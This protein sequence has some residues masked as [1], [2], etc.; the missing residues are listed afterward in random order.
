MHQESTLKKTT[1]T[2]SGIFYGYW[3]LFVGFVYQIVMNGCVPYGFSLFILPID[4]E[5]GWSRAVI[6]TG[7]MIA[8]LITG[9]ASPFVGK[10]IYRIGARWVLAGG[11]LLM[12]IGFAALSMT[13]TVWQFYLLYAVVGIGAAATGVVPT[14]MIVSNWFKK[15]RGLAI[16]ILGT[17]IG[18]G[19]FII[20]LL[21]GTYVIPTFGW[22]TAYLVS[23]VISTVLLIPLA[24]F[25][26]RAKPEDKGLLPDNGETGESKHGHALDAPEPGLTMNEALKTPAFWLMV[27]SFTT[28]GL[29]NAQV[30]QNNAPHLQSI[31]FSSAIAA[32]AVDRKSVV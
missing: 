16:G 32:T 11:A 15:R 18:V 27:V 12:G 8:S 25:L 10:F 17:G 14:S 22:R 29:A 31:G 24:L 9:F 5:F 28:F 20:P 1:K 30:F 21:L 23:A 19:G 13:Q 2:R 6:M 4:K 26:I 3:I 7:N